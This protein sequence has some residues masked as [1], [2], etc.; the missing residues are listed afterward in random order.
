MLPSTT[1]QQPNYPGFPQNYSNQQYYSR[2][3]SAHSQ[4]PP[5]IIY[6]IDAAP[7]HTS[8]PNVDPKWTG[9]D[10]KTI[11]SLFIRKVY[12]VL[13]IQL[14][15][16]LGIIAIFIFVEEVKLFS[17][18]YPGI[19]LVAG[20]LYIVVYCLLICVKPIARKFPENLILLIIYTLAMSYLLG[21]I[22]ASY[23]T[24]IILLAIGICA[25]SCL[26][27]TLLSIHSKFDFTNLGGFMLVL[28]L[29]LFISAILVFFFPIMTVIYASLGGILGITMLA[30]TT[31]LIMGNQD[32]KLDP[33]EYI[34]AVLFLYTDI[35]QIFLV[36]LMFFR[37]CE[38]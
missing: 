1:P 4:S 28:L 29:L 12:L 20:V 30:S 2:Q 19:L 27:V 16:T 8:A 10:D 14:L 17:K 7:E 35:V 9:F 18:K 24:K 5:P 23:R 21:A 3:S 32:Y 6:V 36:I 25:T 34:A 15:F 22:S 11:R 33:E 37:I 26:L 13:L 38:S 31:Q